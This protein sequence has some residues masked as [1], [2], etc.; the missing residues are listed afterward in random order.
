MTTTAPDA[1]APSDPFEAFNRS[2]GIGLIADPHPRWAEMRARA[3]ILETSY[4]ALFNRDVPSLPG[5][6]PRIYTA[7]G[8]EAVVDVLRDGATFSS[9]GYARSMGLVMGRTI[10]EMDEP[11]HGR[12]RSLLSQAFSRRAVQRWEREVVRPIVR[13]RVAAMRGRGRAELIRELT[14]P[15]PVEVI[16][17]MIGIPAEDTER[18]H[19]MAVELISVSFDPAAGMRASQELRALFADLLS[20]RRADPRDDLV[21]VLAHAELDGEPLDEELVYGF[22]RLLAPAG[23]ET[24][25]RSSSNLLAGLLTHPDQLDAVRADRNLWFHAIEEGLRWEPPLTG[26]MRTCVRDCEVQGVAVPADT[27]ISVNMAAANRD[28]ARWDQPNRFDVFR[29]YHRHAAF[30]FGPHTCLGMHLARMETQVLLEELFEGLPGLRLDPDEAP[31]T[32]SGLLFRS[33][34]ALHVRFDA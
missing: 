26:I 2:Q 34:L 29:P 16:A 7:V 9:A 21:S 1:T 20:Q 28:P 12:V 10:L 14:F 15:F 13:G 30:A 8:F 24:T 5:M 32:V 18:F 23:A 3:P 4:K 22:F 6:N 17:E 25:Y 33:P 31:P 11:E 27:T 19:R